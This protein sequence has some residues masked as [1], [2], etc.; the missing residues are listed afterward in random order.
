VDN[1]TTLMSAGVVPQDHSLTDADLG[2]IHSL[3]DD[4]VAS[5]INLKQ[6]LGDDFIQRNGQNVANCFL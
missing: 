2:V 3:S 5:L 6:K 1:L 4:E